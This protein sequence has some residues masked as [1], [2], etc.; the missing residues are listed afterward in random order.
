MWTFFYGIIV[1]IIAIG[2]IP[3]LSYCRTFILIL[4]LGSEKHKKLISTYG[5]IDV[6]RDL[7]DPIF[8]KSPR[9]IISKYGFKLATKIYKP[10]DVIIFGM[11]MMHCS[12]PNLSSKYRISIDTRYQP[13]NEEKDDRFFFKDGKIWKGNFYNKNVN[14]KSID[15]MKSLWEI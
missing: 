9:E 10:G 7:I 4:C 5:N 14:Y 8:S 13:A 11:H 15:L 1:S 3:V 2:V 12:A 6:D